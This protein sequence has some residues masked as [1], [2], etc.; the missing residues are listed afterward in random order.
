MT[1]VTGGDTEGVSEHTILSAVTRQVLDAAAAEGLDAEAIRAA[2]G[3]DPAVLNDP[4]ART[5]LVRHV[6]VWELLSEA[7]DGLAIGARLGLGSLGVV[8]YA[9]QHGATVGEA[10]D[11]LQRFRTLVHP[12][13]VPHLER[14]ATPAGPRLVFRH[15][16]P[17]V[18]ARLRPAVDAYAAGTVATMQALTGRPLRAVRVTFPLTAPP[19]VERYE[20]FFACPVAWAGPAV[21][22][23]F[24]QAILSWPLPR[25]EPRL[26]GYLA[27]RAAALLALVPRDRDAVDAARREIGD[28]LAL[29]EPRLG[30]VAR[31]LGMSERTLHRRLA[32]Q[33][34]SFSVLVDAARRERAELLLGD[35]SLSCSEVAVLLGYAEPAVFFRAFRRW[36][37]TSPRAWRQRV[38]AAGPAAG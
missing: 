30:D 17:P 26:F 31:S 29:G 33:G 9:M 6:R 27:G 16:V 14:R 18:F 37:G 32:E 2:A 34:T 20:R 23:V 19:D 11:W 15:P 3:L 8:G 21:E 36:H 24:D 10:L 1:R 22:V 38:L 35:R 28:G 4:D 5:P 12:G 25:H 7:G 13:L